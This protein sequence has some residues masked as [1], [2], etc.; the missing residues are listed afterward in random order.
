MIIVVGVFFTFSAV[1]DGVLNGF[2]FIEI[3]RI[4]SSSY[5]D[6]SARLNHNTQVAKK[7]AI[8]NVGMEIPKQQYTFEV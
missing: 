2:I 3:V 6:I 5:I 7:Q 4:V 1:G 8:Y